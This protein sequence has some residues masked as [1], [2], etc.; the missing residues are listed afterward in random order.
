MTKVLKPYISDIY[1]LDKIY[2]SKSKMAGNSLVLP[3]VLWGRKAPTHCI[4]AILLMDDVSMIVT[5]CH[6]GQISL[7]DFSLNLEIN[8]RALLFGHTASITCLSKASASSEK[9]YI[10]SASESG[11]M[12]LWDVND[13]RCIEFTKLAYTHTGIQFYQFT[14]GT[15]REG[16]LLCHGHYPEI[17]VVDATS[18]EVLYSLVSKISPDWISSMSIIRSHR[19]QEDN[20]VAVSVTGIL[21]VWIVT[22][23]VSRMQD[24]EPI[25]EEE[26]KPI[27]CQNC[28]SISFCAFTQRSLLVVCS[29]YWRVFDAGDY[30]LL[31]SVPSENGQ[32]WTG[33]DFVSADKVIIWTEDGQSFIYKLPASCLPA[34]DT[35]RSDVG[36]AVENLIPPL[37]FS[38]LDR[39][40][41]QLLICPPVTRFFYGRRECFHKLLIQ[42]DSSGRLCIWSV[43]DTLELQDNTEGLQ[44]TS[45]TSLQEAFCKLTPRPAGII[46]QLSLIPNSNEP[47]KVTASVYIPA[48]GRLVCG[49]EDGSIVI[50]PATQTAIVQLLQGEH[51]LRR[52][53]PPHR[54]LRAHRNKVTCL[55][56]PHQVSSRY[57]HRYLI[58]GGVDFSV[59]IW[60]IFSG[61]M[62]HIF[63]VHGGE[64]TQLLVP[65]ENCSA[66]VQHCICSVASDHSVGLLSLRE[67]K[68]IMLAS[69][70]LFP[71]QVIKWRPSDDYLVVGCVDGS[72]YVWQMDTGALDRCVM[73]IT[74]VEIL[75]A[76]DEAVPA[77]VDS[78]SHPAVNLKQAMTRRSLAALKNVAHQKL[79]TLATNLLASEASDKGNLPKYSHNSLMVQAIKTNLTDP[80][81][82]VLFFDVEALIIQLLTEEAS[83]PNTALIS[84]ENLQKASGSS[85]KG[86]SFLAGKRAAVLFQQVKETIK[87][88]IKEHLLD[89]EDEDDDSVRQRREDSAPEYRSS[90]SKPLTLLEYNLTMDTAKLFMSCLH[91]WGLNEVLDGVCLDRLGMLKPHCSVSFGLLSR[92]GHMS[93]MLP[94]YNQSIGKPSYGSVE[95]GRQMSITEGLGRGTYGVSRA[96]TTQHLLSIISLANTLMS[97]TNATFIGDHMKKGPIRPPRPGTPELSKMKAPLPA[98]SS[99]AQGQ[100]KQGWS[101]LAAMHCVM[102]P[103][104]LGLEKFRPPLLEMLAR[105][106]QDRCLEVREAAQALLLAELRRIEQAGRKETIDAWAPYLP[107]Y[108]DSIISPGVTAEAIQT[109][110]ASPDSSGSEAK[111]QE[112]E[113][114]LVDDDITAGCLSGLPQMKKISTSYEERR[115][116]ATA[117]V[118][119]GVIGAEFGAE[120]EPPKL[121][122]RPRSSSQI[123]EGFGLTSGGSNYSLARH[124]CKALTFLLLQPPSPKLPP[125]STIRRTAIDLIGRGFTVWEP[126]MDV[127]AV[128]MGLLELCADAEK[129]LSNITMGLPLSPAADS[130]RSARHALSLIAT[131]RPPA[132]I[133]TIA[134]EVHRHTALAANTQSQQNIHTTALARAKGEILRVIEILIDKMP[135]DVVDLLVEVMDIL[136][137]CLEGSLV[138]KKGLQECFPA[139]CRFYMVSYYERSHRIAVGARHGSVALY[140]IRTGKCQTIHGHKGPITA[141]AFAP[142]GRYLATY[143][144]TDSHISFWQMNT[145][146]LGSIGMLNSAPQ[147]RCI[148]TYQV[149]PVQPASPGSHNALKLARLIWTSNR[150]VI[151]MAHDGKEHRFMV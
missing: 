95:V 132:F 22:S 30:S 73:G 78:L 139:I 115:K 55:L 38:V 93:L 126:Y 103:D 88:N 25:F 67:K 63:C 16:R 12:C 110:S 138:K 135:T 133:T 142:D 77:A 151:L 124:T 101:Q 37:L 13:G 147:L 92:G 9:Q 51:M 123:P 31:C 64:I 59:V 113:H 98:S 111:V 90:K 125:H 84:P 52:G 118:L 145:S 140:D 7:W 1:D 27:Y 15:Q 150:N 6:D 35:F 56:Y 74:A 62:K 20:V 143:S 34:S 96:V 85:D 112:E 144:N 26:S 108:I 41:K 99:A 58:S 3:I 60:D 83:R 106:W 66:R 131:A 39:A 89:D 71:I 65:P 105:R 29:K 129:Q 75:N 53:W 137:Y 46:D 18:L 32:T 149:P 28:Q 54:S 117:I 50:V 127:S 109:G 40:D 122:T 14:V 91:A 48:H 70:H 10:V 61:E 81:I 128:L 97:M 107:Q 148:K 119:L 72:V 5:G 136:M 11:E 79:Q 76:C 17:L 68:C 114:D 116:Q 80:D 24:T 49:R 130:A 82:H 21:K 87:E 120:I 45:S 104:L 33:G 23:E 141:V 42:G 19:T 100:I 146:L 57:D 44:M 36:K 94:G 86:G 134:K 69:R 2:R 4:S 121:L 102:L 8:P 47:L 43:P